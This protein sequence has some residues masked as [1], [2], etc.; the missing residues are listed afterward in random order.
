M[1]EL[2]EII[3][4][5]DAGFANHGV[6]SQT[7]CL[8]LWGGSLI[9]W[10]SARQPTTATSTSEAELTAA[11]LTVQVG[12]GLRALIEELGIATRLRVKIDNTSALSITELGGSWRSRHYSVRA[13]AIRELVELNELKLEYV[14]TKLQL[15]DCL[16]KA[17]QAPVLKFF[18]E[19][20]LGERP[21]TISF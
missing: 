21:V 20:L 14:S 9:L 12:N 11:S 17:A 18:R 2:E 16:T 7:G 19:E 4:Y 10:R 1:S 3:F 5:S 6:R 15:A 13:T 8:G